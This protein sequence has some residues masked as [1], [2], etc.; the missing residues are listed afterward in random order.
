MMMMTLMMI[1]MTMMMIMM[2]MM[3]I[4]IIIAVTQ[5]RGHIKPTCNNYNFKTTKM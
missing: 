5:H 2:T 4:M 1:M 3:I